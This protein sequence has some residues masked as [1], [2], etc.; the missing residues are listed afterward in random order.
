MK[1][2]KEGAK[3]GETVGVRGKERL[4]ECRTS[5]HVECS[6]HERQR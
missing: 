5:G 2:G 1:N 4:R 6:G 3:D